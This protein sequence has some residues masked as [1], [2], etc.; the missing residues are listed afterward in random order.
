M[1][2][3]EELAQRYHSHIAGP[4]PTNLTGAERTTFIVYDK[5]DERKLRAKVDLFEEAAHRAGRSWRAFDFTP[6]FAR[7]MATLDYRETYF[8][9]PPKLSIKLRKHFLTHAAEQLRAALLAKGVDENTV[10]AVHG[11]GALYGFARLSEVLDLVRT[12]IRGQLLVLFPGTWDN[13]NYRLLDARDG[14]NYLAIPITSFNGL[15]DA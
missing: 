14:W 7:W 10:V 12:D 4:L 1:G 15:L 8:N 2:R 11:V 6:I 3:I 5:A 13:N 9:S